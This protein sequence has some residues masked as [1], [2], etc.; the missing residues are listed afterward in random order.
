MAGAG[1]RP[2]ARTVDRTWSSVLGPL[3][4]GQDLP[5]EGTA[6]AMERLLSGEATPAQ[7]AAFVVALRC[8]GETVEELA[9]LADTMLDFATPI[10]VPGPAV[11]IVGSG[12]DRANTVNIST[13]AAIVAAAAG[14][15]VVKHGNR[16]ASSACGAA[17]VLEALGLTLDLP[18]ERQADVVAATG[19]GFLFAPLYHPALRHAVWRRELG[20]PT[21]F[22]FLGPM[23]NPAQPIA[24]AVGVADARMASLMA[25]VFADRGHQ[26]LVVHG[27]DGLDELTTTTTSTVWVYADGRVT[28][29]ELD[30]AALGVPRA[31]VA[32]LVGGDPSVNAAVVRD[33]LDGR[34]GPVRDVV[35]LNAAAALVAYDGP[36]ADELDDQL[37]AA[38]DRAAT[39]IDSGAGAAKLS[40]WVAAT[41]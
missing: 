18:P 28:Q 39:A 24:Q 6:W 8:K 34:P 33:L 31:D 36:L 26:G 17:D 37:V 40:E 35:G 13:M 22:N 30:P 16:A 21:T 10:E 15:R 41:Q 14:A 9:G 4:A 11:D 3:V 2:A 7:Q 23:S 25:G 29:R 1:T 32:D 20:I 12:G 38:M 5:R 27:G 19:I